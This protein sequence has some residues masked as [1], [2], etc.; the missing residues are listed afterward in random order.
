MSSEVAPTTFKELDSILELFC[1]QITFLQY[2]ALSSVIESGEEI[3]YQYYGN[4]DKYNYNIVL[5]EKLYN[6]LV[7]MKL[8]S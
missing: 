3:N 4:Y 6:K 2:R 1:P 8:I 5:L 7:E